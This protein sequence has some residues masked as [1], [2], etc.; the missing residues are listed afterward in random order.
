MELKAVTF[1]KH[2]VE[3]FKI[4]EE[5]GIKIIERQVIDTL[6]KSLRVEPREDGTFIASSSLTK[7]HIL[8]VIYKKEKQ[9]LK[10]ITFYPARRKD[11]GL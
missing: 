2:A 11:Y 7:K 4:L 1:T 6:F 10:V 3:K 8:R 9:S 5:H